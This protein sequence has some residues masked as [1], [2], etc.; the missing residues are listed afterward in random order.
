[1]ID[2]ESQ[3][4]LAKQAAPVLALLGRRE[5]DAILC[6]MAQALIKCAPQ[7]MEA[8][9]QDV[10]FA[11]QNG[12]REAMI[13]RL[14]LDESRIQA[15]AQGLTKVAGLEDPTARIE[16]GWQR[17]NG[18][19]IEKRRVP[20]GVVGIIYEARPNVTADAVGLCIKSGN[21]C[22]LRG[23]KEAIRSNSAILTVLHDAGVEAGMPYGAVQLVQDTDR[24][25]AHQMMRLNGFID[26]LIPRGGAGLIQSVVQNASVPVIE[27]G[28]G[29]C[30]VYIDRAADLEMGLRI[31]IN[32]KCSRPSVCNAAESLLVHR[33]VAEQFLPQACAALRGQGVELRGCERTRALC[34]DVK[35]AT[36]EDYASEY[37]DLILSIRVVDD[38][39]Q[40]LSHIAQYTTHHSEA[41]VTE[42]VCAA[43]RFL[44]EVDAAA[45]Y[46]NASTRFTD[47]EE[48]GFG[49][50]IGISTQ[51][52]HAR[53]PM[54]LAELTSVK[55][56]VRAVGRSVKRLTKKRGRLSI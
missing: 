28:V 24:A 47:G 38:L 2:V 43:E 23:G 35:A 25:S 7:I 45:V 9:A 10:A 15:M 8:N 5:K 11:R 12:I 46:L 22:V 37:N 21:A 52:L 53:G 20:L 34:P 26:V 3:A 36:Q 44:N 16:E 1:M 51:K 32:A 13:D 48:F 27:T 56:V 39:D 19:R 14:Q 31:L 55:Y 30:H 33:E 4:R 54:G 50:E 49:A 29:N 17:E 6:A 40:A 42:D 18:L 41:I